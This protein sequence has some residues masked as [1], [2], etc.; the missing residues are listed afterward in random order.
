MSRLKA[1]RKYIDEKLAKWIEDDTDRAKAEAHLYGVSSAAALIAQRR[2]MSSHQ[3]EYLELVFHNV[4]PDQILAV[5]T[6]AVPEKSGEIHLSDQL[7][8][9]RNY[10][11]GNRDWE[12]YSFD[13]KIWVGGAGDAV[14]DLS[15]LLTEHE[16][17]IRQEKN[18]GYVRGFLY[19][20][21]R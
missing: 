13:E 20:L 16:R 6:F 21:Y 15:V 14:F 10:S 8:R 5:C 19:R 7:Y 9:L 2:D 11:D 18:S 3:I 17:F 1:L 12:P 4:W